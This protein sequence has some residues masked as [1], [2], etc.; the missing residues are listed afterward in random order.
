MQ[1]AVHWSYRTLS[2]EAAKL[3]RWL[4]VFS[5]PI[6]L[7]TVECLIGKDPLHPLTVL[8]DKSLVQVERA[9]SGITYR[10]LHP[11]R[12]F[13]ARRLTEEGEE[14]SAR[15]RHAAWVWTAPFGLPVVPDV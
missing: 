13:A 12:G 10:V 15:A 9:D 8:V 2:T 11:I 7:S 5:G 3:L 6:D 4:S 14:A 1:A